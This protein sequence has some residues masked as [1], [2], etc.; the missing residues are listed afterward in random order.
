[1][2]EQAFIPTSAFLLGAMLLAAGHRMPGLSSGKVCSFTG[3]KGSLGP[4]EVS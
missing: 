4:R 2:E 3:A 1:M